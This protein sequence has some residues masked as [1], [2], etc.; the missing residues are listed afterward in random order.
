MWRKTVTARI[1]F[2]IADPKRPVLANDQSEEASALREWANPVARGV[3]HPAGDESFDP[4]AAIDD[5]ECRVL[6]AD[7]RANLIDDDLQD[8]VDSPETSDPSDRGVQGNL[9]VVLG[10]RLGPRRR[11]HQRRE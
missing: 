9:D 6:R 1:G 8:I 4:S 7:E 5:P 2:D 3:V 11:G 10:W